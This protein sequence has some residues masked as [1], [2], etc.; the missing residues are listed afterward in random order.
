[1]ITNAKL[2][3]DVLQACRTSKSIDLLDYSQYESGKCNNGGCYS[4]VTTFTKIEGSQDG[5]QVEHST[6][7]EF[8]Y[9]EFYGCFCNNDCEACQPEHEVVTS[10]E[11]ALR[12]ERFISNYT[13][14]DV[15]WKAN[16]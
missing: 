11:V 14:E 16:Q 7:A 4:F 12:V 10:K 1:M 3:N 6:S 8:N 15:S 2:Y 13:D 5:W 9:C